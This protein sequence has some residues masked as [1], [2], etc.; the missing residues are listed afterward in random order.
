MVEH[1]R[2][3]V[4]ATAAAATAS[5]SKPASAQVG[6]KGAKAEKSAAA[7]R[8]KAAAAAA[9]GGVPPVVVPAYVL[10]SLGTHR[11]ALT[12]W[13]AGNRIYTASFVW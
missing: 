11:E 3:E 9:N 5:A 12:L 1:H 4:D 10:E 8:D 6:D 2:K 7:G 13:I